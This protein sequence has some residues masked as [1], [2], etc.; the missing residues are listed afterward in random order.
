MAF[1][2]ADTRA[3]VYA[4][5]VTVLFI[6]IVTL[7]DITGL[8]ARRIMV[9]FS[10][11][12]FSLTR[13]KALNQNYIKVFQVLAVTVFALCVTKAAFLV[14]ASILDARIPAVMLNA[15]DP[16]IFVV[17]VEAGEN[18]LRASTHRITS[19]YGFLLPTIYAA[20]KT[21]GFTPNYFTAYALIYIVNVCFASI[22]LICT[23][24]TINNMPKKGWFC[25]ILLSLL[26]YGPMTQLMLFGDL[27]VLFPNLSAYRF[28]PFGLVFI[29]CFIGERHSLIKK[30]LYC[31]FLSAF[32]LYISQ[33]SGIVS[34]CGFLGIVLLHD[35]VDWS[36]LKRGAAFVTATTLTVV[37]LHVLLIATLQVDILASIFTSFT[38]GTSGYGGKI[39]QWRDPNWI[40]AGVCIF[41]FVYFATRARNEV[42][43]GA[44]QGAAVVSGMV[45]LWYVYYVYRPAV[46]YWIY[47]AT[48]YP[49]AVVIW[50]EARRLNSISLRAAIVFALAIVSYASV[51]LTFFE[52]EVAALVKAG[53]DKRA[54]DVFGG[55]RTDSAWVEMMRA[56]E[57]ELKQASLDNP[58]VLPI[59]ALPFASLQIVPHTRVPNETLFSFNSP[60]RLA[61]WRKDL[62]GDLPAAILFD[63]ERLSSYDRVVSN[64]TK[65]R[66]TENIADVYDATEKTGFVEVWRIKRDWPDVASRRCGPL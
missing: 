11:G 56:R 39:I 48:I 37:L 29:Y 27:N 13:I 1:G 42:L 57:R 50:N 66:V 15:S 33:D 6:A 12:L 36:A 46:E 52:A 47:S 5:F 22:W 9:D 2:S 3:Q 14:T 49:L 20:I 51:S 10:I 61:E 17:F 32:S 28:V 55:V 4:Y 40:V 62:C 23:L 19:G 8:I 38:S 60:A 30:I 35:V 16:H 7:F 21:S 43:P 26:S 64:G 24:F 65:A 18:I 45:L 63:G 44:A 34:I 41:T 59:T 31:S 54:T 53:G 25:I 58:S